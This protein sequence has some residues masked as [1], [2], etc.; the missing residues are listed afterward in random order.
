MGVT[1]VLS[2]SETVVQLL[3]SH[4]ADYRDGDTPGGGY[5][6][7]DADGGRLAH[8]SGAA[9]DC[10]QPAP[11]NDSAERPDDQPVAAERAP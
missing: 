2:Q 7:V 11:A 3:G 4:I 6:G 8:L 5:P 10:G 1:A 9:D